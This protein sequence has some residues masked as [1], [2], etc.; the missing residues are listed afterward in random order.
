MSG[1]RELLLC[2]VE[3]RGV[4]A[5]A[6]GQNPLVFATIT[7]SGETAPIL[8]TSAVSGSQAPC[9]KETLHLF[10]QLPF[11]LPPTSHPYSS[12]RLRLGTQIR[13][14]FFTLFF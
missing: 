5:A 4:T 2:V 13:A 6:E 8:Q 7:R 14:F 1:A 11:P 10:V 3:A 12:L 9:W